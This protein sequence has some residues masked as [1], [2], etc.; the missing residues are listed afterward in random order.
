MRSEWRE[1]IAAYRECVACDPYA[2]PAYT[3]L[4]TALSFAGEHDEARRALEH[5]LARCGDSLYLREASIVAALQRGDFAIARALAR[6]AAARASDG[7]RFEFRVAQANAGLGD[8]DA[9]L[10]VLERAS[11]VAP[12][13]H[14]AF[15]ETMV[16]SL[17]ADADRCVGAALRAVHERTPAS[18]W[19]MA[20][21]L[22]NRHRS[23]MHW[24]ALCSATRYDIIA[25]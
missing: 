22:V 21:P 3:G 14:V 19:L 12:A 17:G 8:T 25:K 7:W 1:S 18:L 13:R 9:A 23:A 16:H 5:A 2:P 11:Q 10:A 24:G 20:D 15:L 6:E 4:S